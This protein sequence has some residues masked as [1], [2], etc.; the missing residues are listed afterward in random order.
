MNFQEEE[1][2]LFRVGIRME[3]VR[4]DWHIIEAESEQA[5]EDLLDEGADLPKAC[6]TSNLHL[7]NDHWKIDEVHYADL[8]KGERRALEAQ[9]ARYEAYSRR[10]AE[11][12]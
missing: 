8:R 12:A 1:M 2:K 7:G 3:V 11:G 5:V 4:T 9:R 10:K 6:E